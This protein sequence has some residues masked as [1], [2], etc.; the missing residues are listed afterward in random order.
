MDMPAAS[1]VYSSLLNF[2]LERAT[3]EDILAFQLPESEKERAVDLLD[4]QDE[5]ALTLEEEAELQRMMV[6]EG[7]LLELKARAMLAQE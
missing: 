7:L 6:M 3:P 5:D 2:I 4:K 1:P